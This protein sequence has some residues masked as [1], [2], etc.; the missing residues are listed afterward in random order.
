[1]GSPI[2]C[3]SETCARVWRHSWRG[4]RPSS[5]AAKAA[6]W[7]RERLL[8]ETVAAICGE[9]GPSYNARKTEAGETPRELWDALAERGYLGVNLPERWGVEEW[10]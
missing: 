9:F 10:A 1:M 4:A 5:A 7:R 8:R 3:A 6:R 2:R